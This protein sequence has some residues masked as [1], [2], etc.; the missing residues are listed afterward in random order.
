MYMYLL[1]LAM[2]CQA[3]SV[4]SDTNYRLNTPIKPKAYSIAITPYFNTNDTNAFTFDGE[5]DIT[6]TTEKETNLIKLHSQDLIFK[7][8]NIKILNGANS[9]PL[10]VSNPLEFDTNYTFA[11]INLQVDLQIG[12]EY[13]LK[14]TYRGPIRADLNGFYRNYYIEK[15]VKK[16]IFYPTPIMSTYLVAFMV[17]EFE[18]IEHTNGTKEFGIF[19]RP[20]ALNQT[21]YALDFGMKVV[22]A[23]GAYFGID[24]YSTD[25]HLKLDH[26]ALPDFNAGAMENWGLIK[27][28][29]SLLL[30][31]PE[32]STP[33]YKYRVAQIVAHETTHMWFGNL[34]TC[35]WWSNTWLNEGF[36][37][38]FQDY[39]TAFVDPDVASANVLVTGSVYAAYDAD[40]TP[41]SSPITNENVNSPA[42]ISGHFGTITYQKA[43]SVIRM[44]HHLIGDAGFRHGLNNY[45]Q[46]NKFTSGYPDK[47]FKALDIGVQNTSSLAMYPNTDI[48]EVMSSW[49][50]QAG[51]PILHVDINYE[52]DNVLLTQKRFYT[53]SSYSSN[54]TYNIPI[55]YTTGVDPDFIITKPVMVMKNKTHEFSIP[56]IHEDRRWIVND[57]FAFLFADEVSFTRLQ[58]VLE[59]MSTETDYSVWYAAIRGL[60]KLWHTYL[61]SEA[62]ADI[63]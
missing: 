15:G 23:L 53:N 7:D 2:L 55:T 26:I 27:Y 18:G 3:S 57:L 42:E 12:V 40:N 14:I 22:D 50:S 16:E 4:F 44:M 46:T 13:S 9:I 25:A 51:H 41:T 30:Y 34:V 56:G 58:R 52:T 43:G 45:L 36:A 17:S 61:G 31:V 24:Y 39:I 48:T 60:N 49:I 33:Y 63:E 20:E 47:L 29:E 54:E 62:L 10:S 11:F 28:R 1:T 6:F 19:T 21:E 37:N 8:A 38:Y 5:V 59:F 35:H 32:D